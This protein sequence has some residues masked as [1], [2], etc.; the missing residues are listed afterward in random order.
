MS[1]LEDPLRVLLVDPNGD[2]RA[3]LCATLASLK[4]SVFE[5]DGCSAALALYAQADPDLILLDVADGTAAR[6]READPDRRVPIGLLCAAQDPGTLTRCLE[7]GADLA[8]PRQPGVAALRAVL[9]GAEKQRALRRKLVENRE[10]LA[11]HASRLADEMQLARSLLD[12]VM[13]GKVQCFPELHTWIFPASKFSGDIIVAEGSPSGALHVMLA[14]GV[15]HGLA[16]TFVV[17]P[18]ARTFL[19]MTL[20]GFGLSSIAA[21]LNERIRS[22]DFPGLFVSAAL[23]AYSPGKLSLEVWNGG[24]PDA[25]LIGEEGDLVRRFPS[26]HVPLGVLGKREM[27]TGTDTVEAPPGSQIFF[28]SDGLLEAR[29]P[30][31]TAFGEARLIDSLAWCAPPARYHTVSASI[32]SFLGGREAHDDISLAVL[33]CGGVTSK[34]S[35]ANPSDAVEVRKLEATDMDTDWS[36]NLRLGAGRL[37]C[38][39]IV[40]MVQHLVKEIDPDGVDATRLFVLLSELFNNALDHGLLGLDSRLKDGPEGIERYLDERGRR[41]AALKCGEIEIELTRLSAGE[42]KGVRIRVRDSGEGFDHQGLLNGE[43]ASPSA[44]YGRGIHLVRSLASSVA[45]SGG[46]NTVEALCAA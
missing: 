7:S 39:D 11:D 4:Q 6:L 14:D 27:D 3:S 34:R 10:Q 13:R 35:V 22:Y 17:L 2:R 24:C 12:N 31:N 18:L 1:W 16:A 23:V 21:E 36:C 45:Y 43:P 9:G 32:R 30:G 15:G 25:L 8:L 28:Y 37:K 20:K 26:R 38:I 41:L 42:T 33:N 44:P 5:V 29:G 19:T 46:G 40:P